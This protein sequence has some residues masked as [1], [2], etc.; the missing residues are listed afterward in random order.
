MATLDW[1]KFVPHMPTLDWI[2]FVPHTATLD[3]IELKLHMATL[4]WIGFV[5]YMA[6]LGWIGYKQ[7]N[8]GVRFIFRLRRQ[9]HPSLYIMY[10]NI[11]GEWVEKCQYSNKKSFSE[12][13]RLS[14]TNVSAGAPTKSIRKYFLDGKLTFFPH[15]CIH[16]AVYI[17][18]WH[19]DCEL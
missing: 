12:G 4:D 14:T 8:I 19:K 3:W 15:S 18:F 1:I 7:Q 5:P 6:T 10:K 2:E 16:L 17:V 11:Q 9:L 13:V